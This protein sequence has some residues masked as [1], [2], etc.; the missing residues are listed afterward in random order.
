MK[1]GGQEKPGDDEA[2][3]PKKAI[4]KPPPS[5]V[6]AGLAAPDEHWEVLMALHGYKESPK[7]WADYRDVELTN[8]KAE[9]NDD[10]WLSLDQI[11]TEPNMWRSM[12]HQVS[13]SSTTE[14][15][16]G[17]LLVYVDDLLIL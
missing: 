14:R 8:L 9:I 15:S 12:K 4:I 2:P 16:C 17:I 10:T 7:L 1:L 5:L 11:I 3:Q 6:A 13:G